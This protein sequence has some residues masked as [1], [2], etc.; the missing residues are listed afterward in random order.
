MMFIR[1]VSPDGTPASCHPVGNAR[2]VRGND[3]VGPLFHLDRRADAQPP[4]GYEWA[5]TE[6]QFVERV[7][8]DAVPEGST[9]IEFVEG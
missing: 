4:A 7:A 1:Y 3:W 5:E 9:S 2:L 6:Q 8:R